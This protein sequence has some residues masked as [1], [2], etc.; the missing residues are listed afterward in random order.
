[1]TFRIEFSPQTLPDVDQGSKTEISE[2]TRK[3]IF[4]T[5]YYFFTPSTLVHMEMVAVR[6]TLSKP[7]RP[8]K[9]HPLHPY[10]IGSLSQS[11]P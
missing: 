6:C 1:M 10:M 5:H 11:Q 8:F 3:M 7:L 2:L 4:P 9:L